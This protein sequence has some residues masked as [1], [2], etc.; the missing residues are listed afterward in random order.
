MH[1]P[2]KNKVSVNMLQS[3]QM[4]HHRC[5]EASSGCQAM[6]CLVLCV[7]ES[8]SVKGTEIQRYKIL[9]PMRRNN[10]LL[11]LP[12]PN[13]SEF[14]FYVF[15]KLYRPSCSDRAAGHSL[16]GNRTKG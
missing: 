13:G 14:G 4:L 8:M 9:C 3:I 5:C 2:E 12:M 10:Q 11:N 6:H 15:C 16:K 1:K 7:R